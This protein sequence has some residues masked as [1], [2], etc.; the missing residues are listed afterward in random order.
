MTYDELCVSR[1]SLTSFPK[2]HTHQGLKEDLHSS[3]PELLSTW[4]K[5]TFLPQP[6]GCPKPNNIL[7]KKTHHGRVWLPFTKLFP[8]SA[9]TQSYVMFSSLEKAVISLHAWQYNM[10]KS[11]H[12]PGL[13]SKVLKS[14]TLPLFI[15]ASASQMQSTSRAL[16]GP[17]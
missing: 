11:K 4:S 3:S 6:L 17:K 2:K 7:L 5:W 13:P 14:I 10:G 15:L 1:N 12:G 9:W 16:Q 8:F